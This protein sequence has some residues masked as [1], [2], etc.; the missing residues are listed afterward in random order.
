MKRRI[1]KLFS[2]AASLLG[3]AGL[4]LLLLATEVR[5]GNY[6]NN[7]VPPCNPS[8]PTSACYRPLDPPPACEP[9]SC[10]KCTKSP[11]Y[12]GSGVYTTAAVDLEVRAESSP[13]AVERLYLSSH[14][15]DGETGYGWV[16]GLSA[17]LYHSVFLKAPPDSFRGDDREAHVRLPDGSL[18]RF[19]ENPDGSYTPPPG[20]FDELVRR[21]DGSW[22]L[23]LQR[24][25]VHLSFSATGELQWQKDEFGNTIEWEYAKERLWR[26]RDAVSGRF[27]EVTW[28]GDGR[29]SDVVD[30]SGRSVHYLYENGALVS[31]T[32]PLE[33]TTS[34]A[35]AAGRFAPLLRSIVDPWNR[36][37]TDIAYDAQDR[38]RSY[39][40]RGEVYT[41]SYAHGGNKF[42]TRKSDSAGNAWIFEYDTAGL[43]TVSWPPGTV[44]APGGAGASVTQYDGRG[45]LVSRTDPV[46]VRTTATYDARGNLSSITYAAG[47][48][49]AVRFDYSYDPHF[50][51][52]VT[53]IIPRDPVTNQIDSD[54][55]GTQSD[56]Y[57][58]GSVAPGALHHR[59]ELESDGL[60]AHP[61]ATYTYDSRGR[62]L[63]MTDAGGNVTTYTYD[64][65][66]SL[67]TVTSPPNNDAGIRPV[68]QFAHD[69]LGRVV[70]RTDPDG[71][72]TRY[73]WD[74]LDRV[75]ST[76]F[77]LPSA[78]FPRPFTVTVFR[79]EFDPKSG[80]TFARAVDPNGRET[81]V[82]RDQ[83]GRFVTSIEPGGHVVRKVY[84]GL[85]TVEQYDTNENRTTYDY[86]VLHRL[87]TI[88][89]P[90]QT[91]V[92]F[93]HYADGNVHTRR[94]RAG[95][96]STATYDAF[97]RIATIQHSDGRLLTNN[98][99]GK[100]LESV[101]DVRGTSTETTT[102]TW[103]TAFRPL[104][105]TQG[106]RGTIT[107][108]Y[109]SDG[110]LQSRS[111]EGGA[112][113]TVGF[114]PS[115]ALRS[116][117][118][119]LV[120]GT[121][122]YEYLPG[123]LI[124]RVTY[125]NQQTREHTYDGQGRLV[126]LANTHPVTG[127][128]ATFDYG[129]DVDPFTGALSFLGLRTTVTATVPSMGLANAT[130][131]LS[132]DVRE[133]LA[134]AD[135][136][137][138]APYGAQSVQWTYD[139]E[140]NR[141]TETVNGTTRTYDYE[142][143]GDNVQNGLRLLSDGTNSYA[144]DAKGN[145]TA[146]SGSRGSFSFAWEPTGL[147]RA[148]S[149]DASATFDYDF[150]SRRTTSASSGTTT[151]FLYDDVHAIAATSSAGRT[152]YLFAP[153]YDQ[154]LAMVK[155]GAVHYYATDGLGSV[156]V[157]NDAGG[158][159]ANAYAWDAWGNRVAAVEN[160]SNALGFTAREAA[161]AGLQFNR[162]RFYEPAT[163][164]FVSEDPLAYVGGLNTYLYAWADPLSFVD[165][166]GLAAIQICY[167]PDAAKGNGHLGFGTSND[168]GGTVGNYPA[169]GMGIVPGNPG[170]LRWDQEEVKECFWQPVLPVQEK[171]MEKCRDNGPSGYNL[172]VNNCKDFVRDCLTIC[173]LLPRKNYPASPFPE[174]FYR[175]LTASR[176]PQVHYPAVW[177]G[178]RWGMS[179]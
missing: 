129:Y 160:E 9:L 141:L 171:C 103:D 172:F 26:I 105:E 83:F 41:Y 143:H 109:R 25:R 37:I 157:V 150:A 110:T 36:T 1:E 47:T 124:R 71:R 177:W 95:Q 78:D 159:A 11:C 118:W 123:G 173:G 145:L 90:D 156:A 114:Y 18:Y 56:Y 144:Y 45:L 79:D 81:R 169:A 58:P 50:P 31:V 24:T 20:R 133:F 99:R 166:M 107:Y 5:A 146:R 139:G 121:F 51:D 147:L 46:G 17:R 140:G 151:S 43:V 167:F 72:V 34:Y 12:V 80:L 111:V 38:V 135:Y 154:A 136:P 10:G 44:P 70:A 48:S 67:D 155:N 153:G 138:G 125:P 74:A 65:F 164:R 77:P 127:N 54:W 55:Q 119:S 22:D 23:R 104:T 168:G 7:P 175:A 30:S 92:S 84:T 117:E 82:G 21:P 106:D 75:T 113:T 165:P 178:R 176:P 2:S 152:D 97:K 122:L 73:S 59:Y 130:T 142:H 29:L 86:D 102:F 89:Y 60:T 6:C 49:S 174:T 88:T 63:T 100:K 8:D 76:T 40:D 3:A 94:D 27:L 148:I 53:S 98:F 131:K 32:N 85:R 108:A 128:L 68:T 39:S 15:I 162:R 170:E 163:G 93:T 96:T 115:G 132:Y 14:M 120:P 19:V 149:G 112:T 4:L 101:V 179:L 69:S 87:K 16:S 28:G 62:V 126:R 64:S 116:M 137:A 35:Y 57:P 158:T 91:F 61:V 42:A 33:Q 52:Q 13:I 161:P 134:R 66:G